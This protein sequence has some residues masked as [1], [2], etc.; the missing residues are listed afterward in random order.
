MKY[1]QFEWDQKKE[2]SNIRKHGI[3]FEE[4]KT[5]FY[6]CNARVIYDPDHLENEDRYILLGL[7]YKL[8]LIIVS[9]CYRKK[10]EIIRII[11]AR[12]A[13]KHESQYYGGIL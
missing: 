7:S 3:T 1:I 4:A 5:A 9:H 8:R 13:N 6:D 10:Q 11:S 2:H 12:Q